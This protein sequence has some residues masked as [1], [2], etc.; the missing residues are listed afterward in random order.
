MKNKK[1]IMFLLSGFIPLF[2][3]IIASLIEGYVPFGNIQLNIYDSFTQYPG[4]ILALKNALTNGSIFYS[5]GGCGGFNLF[6][7]LAYY[8]MGPL[9]I[10]S[11]FANAN[12]YSIF[13]TIM[14]YIRTFALGLTMCLYLQKKNIKPIYIVLFSTLYALMGFT[15]TYYYNFMWIDGIIMLPLVIYGLDKLIDDNLPALYIIMLFLTIVIN[16]YIGYIIGI[17]SIIYYIYRLIITKNKKSI[18]TFVIS[19]ILSIL[20]SSFILLPTFFSLMLG[21]SSGFNTANY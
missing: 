11:I 6:S 5:W 13:I 16:F 7:T 9:N 17:F 3:F 1:I 20:L 12:N 4:F 15:S 21:K 2:I 18:K 8:G 10:L 19:T 14:T